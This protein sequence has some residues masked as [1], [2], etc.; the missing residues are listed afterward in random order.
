MPS[1]PSFS[2]PWSRSQIERHQEC[3]LAELFSQ[4]V[5]ANP[6]WCRKYAAAGVDLDS[7]T[8]LAHLARLPLTTKAEIVAD[9]RAH[10]PYGTNLTFPRTAYV[11]LHQTSGT[12]GEPMRWLD[13]AASWG[14][15]LDCWRQ[16]FDWMGLKPED[17]LIFPFSFGPFLGFWAGFEGACRQG[18]LCIAAGGMS[19]E[20]R[21][22]AI[23]DNNVT[24]V[25]C[26]PTYALRLVEVGVETGMALRDSPVRALLVA[27]E[28]GGNVPATRRQIEEG[29]GARVF[30]HWGMTE[31]GPLAI[32]V[33]SQPG[34]LTV[35]ETECVAEILDPQTGEPVPAGVEGELVVTNLGRTGSPLIRYRTGDR[36]RRSGDCGRDAFLRLDGGILG[37]TD[38]MLTIR[39]NNIYPAALEDLIRSIEEIA[40]FRVRVEHSRGMQQL[41]IELEPR[42]GLPAESAAGLP[43]RIGAAIRLRFH[44]Q[45]EVRMVGLGE[46]PRFEMKSRRF[47][48]EIATETGG[49]PST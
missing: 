30:D 12:T 23:W 33:E 49:R 13:T 5:P 21:L 2:E 42:S 34:S 39:G 22:K 20:A 10:S 9:Q 26:T 48:R 37:R 15:V 6:F 31:L 41:Q 28:P 17:R 29:W 32:E 4:V 25:C 43:T 47:Q 18:N 44:L 27:G 46:L 24:I 16:L 3:R 7:I 45:P 8:S 36:V 40:E 19:S 1:A 35:L 38:E 14:W 11:R